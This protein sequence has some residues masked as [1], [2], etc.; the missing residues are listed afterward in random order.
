MLIVYICILGSGLF[1][2]D[3]VLPPLYWDK[4]IHLPWAR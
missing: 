4:T 2:D 1:I 3:V